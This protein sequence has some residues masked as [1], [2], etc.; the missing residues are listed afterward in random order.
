MSVYFDKK[1]QVWRWSFNRV[2]PGEGRVRLTKRLPKGWDRAKAEA[3]DRE[4]S[5]RLYGVAS[6]VIDRDW[7]IAGAVALYVKHRIPELKDGHNI[8]AE[9]AKLYGGIEGRLLQDVA[10][11][12]R[13]YAVQEGKTLSSGTIR[14]RLSYLRSAVR[15]AQRV[16]RYGVNGT[17]VAI[18]VQCVLPRPSNE[19]QHFLRHDDVRRLL[20]R[21]RNENSK[22]VF[23]L[24]YYTGYR[25]VKEILP[26]TQDDIRQLDG[27]T[28]LYAGTT[29]NGSPRMKP[30][31][32]DALWALKHIPFTMHWRTYY[33]Y[34]ERARK[35]LGLDHIWAHDLRHS[36]ASEIISNGG[37]LED[38]RGALHHDSVL[39]AK[40]YAHLYPERLAKTMLGVGK[41]RAPRKRASKQKRS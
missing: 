29:K 6:K 15:Y 39:S 19:R 7:T 30:V 16:H 17:G 41:K 32:K 25:W 18:A 2:V 5:G 36:L 11:V 35:E 33:K 1:K 14:N 40:R 38:V 34:F 3:Y 37:T 27:T 21:I 24:A 13:S 28:W 9:L 20:D 8:A 10:D 23:T 12:A 4:R 26:R 22:A 31:H